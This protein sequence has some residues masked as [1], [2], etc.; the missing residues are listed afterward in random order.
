[1]ICV[2]VDAEKADIVML[3]GLLF[4]G[5]RGIRVERMWRLETDHDGQW[6]GAWVIDLATGE[7]TNI[8]AAN[9]VVNY[10]GIAKHRTVVGSHVRTGSD[11]MLVAPVTVGADE[12]CV[13]PTPHS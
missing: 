9:V 10:D 7:E 1:M 8:G 13:G 11:T 4:P 2:L 12:K 6:W 5:V 3:T